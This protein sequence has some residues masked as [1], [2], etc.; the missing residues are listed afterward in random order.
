MER[1]ALATLTAFVA[2]LSLLIGAVP[3][4]AAFELRWP[5]AR[6]AAM[7]GCD[8]GLLA[9]PTVGAGLPGEGSADGSTPRWSVRL[10]G[11]QLFGLPEA[12]GA[13]VLAAR[14][15][16]SGAIA[17]E[18]STLGST[19]YSERQVAVIAARRATPDLVVGVGVRALGIAAAG[20]DDLWS[21]GL[22]VGFRRRILGRL[23]L[24]ARFENIN[25]PTIGGS[26]VSRSAHLLAGFSL[27]VLAI[28]VSVVA[29][30]GFPV[31]TS[32]GLEAVASDWL[33]LRAGVGTEPGRLGA[34][35]GIGKE[36]PAGGSLVPVVDVG[37]QWHPELGVSTFVS[38]SF[39]R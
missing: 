2:A 5:D 7:V 38:V 30:P 21:V 14:S 13:G 16:G 23:V 28:E 32:L 25:A 27:D 3:A 17:V 39:R 9:D 1:H 11:G 29:E 37:W 15:L 34:G 36:R 24:A 18:I 4:G 19:L 33:R 35:V 8:P 26:P 22:D 12:R 6:S 31:S 20:V 10:S